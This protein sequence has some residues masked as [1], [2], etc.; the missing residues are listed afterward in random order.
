MQRKRVY[1]RATI[2]AAQLLGLQVVVAR[3]ERQWS[4]RELAERAGITQPTLRKVERGDPT[5]S[6]GV[7]FELATLVGVPLFHDDRARVT[8]DLDRTRNRAALLPRRPPT[9]A[10]RLKDDF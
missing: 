10:Q 9:A 6:L 7:A 5:V 4:A 3:R 8:L 1:S 2:E